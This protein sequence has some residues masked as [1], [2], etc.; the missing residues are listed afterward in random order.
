MNQRRKHERF[1]TDIP[2]RL[3]IPGSGKGA[4][5]FE[6]FGRLRDLSLGGVFVESGLRFKH[7]AELFIELKLKDGA[8]PVRGKVVR[9]P[10]GG[11]GI[12]FDDLKRA[13]QQ[14]LL[15]HFIPAAHREFHAE[16]VAEIVPKLT[17]DRLSLILHLWDEWRGP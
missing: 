14:R 16:V 13:D 9:Q 17:V 10:D 7:N 15:K 1:E 8:L 3:Y 5:R 2:C 11:L 6:A 12:A 4:V